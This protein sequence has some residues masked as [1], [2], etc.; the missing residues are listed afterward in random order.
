MG[1]FRTFGT[2]ALAEYILHGM[3]ASAVR[4]YLPRDAPLWYAI[5]GTLLYFAISWGLIRYLEK[6]R[7]FLKL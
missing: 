4:P 7:I 5:A 1:L 6:N 2:N 3:V